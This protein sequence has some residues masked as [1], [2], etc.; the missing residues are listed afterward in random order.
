[1]YGGVKLYLL[2]I[3]EKALEKLR[4]RTNKTTNTPTNGF[5]SS[6]FTFTYTYLVRCSADVHLSKSLGM[7][8]RIH[9][10]QRK[11][12]ESLVPKIQKGKCSTSRQHIPSRVK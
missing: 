8:K 10:G 3:G 12:N 7:V 1:M 4:G 5:P 9:K 2:Q 11:T 6:I